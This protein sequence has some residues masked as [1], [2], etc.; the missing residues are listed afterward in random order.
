MG[1]PSINCLIPIKPYHTSHGNLQNNGVNR[2][3]GVV[4]GY[5]VHKEYDVSNPQ[6]TAISESKFFRLFF[7]LIFR[8][9]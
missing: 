6:L 3:L 1:V 7:R 9:F 2:N 5:Y 8:L 4:A